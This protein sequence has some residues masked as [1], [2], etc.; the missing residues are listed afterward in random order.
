[1]EQELIYE[2]II[3]LYSDNGKLIKTVNCGEFD[4]PS[5]EEI[6]AAIEGN[7]ADHATVERVYRMGII[8]FT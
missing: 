2:F 5:E 3:N 8:P 7:G 1:M 4:F 6:Q